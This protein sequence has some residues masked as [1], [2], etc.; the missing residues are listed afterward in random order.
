[1]FKRLID[2]LTPERTVIADFE[3]QK[4]ILKSVVIKIGNQ[5]RLTFQNTLAPKKKRAVKKESS[6]PDNATTRRGHKS[7]MQQ[8]G[9][10]S[11]KPPS[12][13]LIERESA[14]AVTHM[15]SFDS[16]LATPSP[17]VPTIQYSSAAFGMSDRPSA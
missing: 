11:G 3:A 8:T 10:S 1:M 4:K 14:P 7:K 9:G 17:S 12:S 15:P 16:A 5:L 13:V 2:V 6:I